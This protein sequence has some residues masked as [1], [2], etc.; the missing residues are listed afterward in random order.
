MN[1]RDVMGLSLTMEPRSY[2]SGSKSVI[3]A[4]AGMGKAYLLASM[5]SNTLTDSLTKS[6]KA[7]SASELE[8]KMNTAALA[9]YAGAA[10]AAGIASVYLGKKLYGTVQSA[11]QL[12]KTMLD[13]NIAMGNFGNNTS[14]KAINEN[15]TAVKNLQ[16]GIYD[17]NETAKSYFAISSAG[18][19][20]Q[21]KLGKDLTSMGVKYAQ[22]YQILSRGKVSMEEAANFIPELIAKTGADLENQ[23]A[24]GETQMERYMDM[25]GKAEVLTKIKMENM[26]DIIDA[27]GA[28]W[29][30]LGVSFSAGL[31]MVGQQMTAGQSARNAGQSSKS[32]YDKFVNDIALLG[33][34]K[35]LYDKSDDMV[36]KISDLNRQVLKY[37][38]AI[39][40]AYGGT[41][42]F[43]KLVN[44]VISGK[45]SAV[46]AQKDLE[47]KRKDGK[48]TSD[49]F[50]TIHKYFSQLSRATDSNLSGTKQQKR[51]L[52]GLSYLYGDEKKG[53]MDPSNIEKGREK[54][55]GMITQVRAGTLS[56]NAML[57]ELS[58][59]LDVYRK[60][61]TLED[62]N[63]YMM[64]ARMIFPESTSFTAFLNATNATQM[65]KVNQDVYKTDASGRRVR[66][67][68]LSKEEKDKVLEGVAKGLMT[69]NAA[70]L[71]KLYSKGQTIFGGANALMYLEEA[72]KDSEKLTARTFEANMK[73]YN[74]VILETKANL[75]S[76]STLVGVG[77]IEPMTTMANAMKNVT[78]VMN[79]FARYMPGFAS[80]VGNIGG[81]GAGVSGIVA[82]AMGGKALS[83]GSR[84][85][86]SLLGMPGKAINQELINSKEGLLNRKLGLMEKAAVEESKIGDAY[87][88]YNN[89]AKRYKQQLTIN[90]KKWDKAVEAGA[91]SK[92][93]R[94]AYIRGY[95]ST[96]KTK[97]SGLAKSLGY[98][99]QVLNSYGLNP[100]GYISGKYG[101][102]VSGIN[103]R[104]SMLDRSLVTNSGGFMANYKASMD[105][106][107]NTITLN[108]KG[109]QVLTTKFGKFS[110]SLWEGTK[111]GSR[112]IYGR[113][114][115]SPGAM[116]G[117][118]IAGG[119]ISWGIQGMIQNNVFGMQDAL[120][121]FSDGRQGNIPAF[122]NN[123]KNK[124]KKL[125]GG[126]VSWDDSLSAIS[127]KEVYDRIK[128]DVKSYRTTAGDLLSYREWFADL[129]GMLVPNGQEIAGPYNELLAS[130]QRAVLMSLIKKDF[131]PA[132]LGKNA[133]D[134]Y[135]TKNEVLLD[136]LKLRGLSESSLKIL[137]SNPVAMEQLRKDMI[138]ISSDKR[139]NEMADIHK[140]TQEYF[141]KQIAISKDPW[142]Y[143]LYKWFETVGSKYLYAIAAGVGFGALGAG[144]LFGKG[145]L[146]AVI[147]L[148][149][150][151][152]MSILNSRDVDNRTKVIELVGTSIAT[153][154]GGI[155][156]GFIGGTAGAQWVAT[157]TGTG[158]SGIFNLYNAKVGKEDAKINSFAK[159][160]IALNKYENLNA[161]AGILGEYS[162]G[163]YSQALPELHNG[164]YKIWDEAS[165]KYYPVYDVDS[166]GN[167]QM[168]L[169]D[170]INANQA[171]KL[172]RNVFRDYVLQDGKAYIDADVT[173]TTTN[174]FA[175]KMAEISAAYDEWETPTK[176]DGT[177]S[178]E[179]NYAATMGDDYRKALEE[180]TA[181]SDRA[182][183]ATIDLTKTLE[184][185][186]DVWYFDLAASEKDMYGR[187]TLFSKEKKIV[188][189]D[190]EG[191]NYDGIPDFRSTA[192]AE[193]LQMAMFKEG[194]GNAVRLDIFVND[195]FA[196]NKLVNSWT[197]P[198]FKPDNLSGKDW[199][200]ADLVTVGI[201]GNR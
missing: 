120:G 164:V 188:T 153:V 95:K 50:N 171:R 199:G 133:N 60:G 104:I 10:G 82:L 101:N 160:Y 193:E 65:T 175:T 109:Q 198:G 110:K 152:V 192:T 187:S 70:G 185:T 137:E 48:V 177:F 32:I 56:A 114:L 119:L 117:T 102:E 39:A 75:K 154:A 98:A 124:S 176:S 45:V 103:N 81:A 21:N 88:K 63:K 184:D 35:V 156:G 130:D 43:Q 151:S 162:I 169:R 58:D 41:A 144:A 112:A 113:T 38:E 189:P 200:R 178:P 125:T 142:A 131:A 166:E 4:T 24:N 97:T 179:L 12:Q 11:T 5:N 161:T 174:A 149:G 33:S 44:D 194:F 108:N 148:L 74:N 36:A 121:S 26:R 62:L 96:I 25:M 143:N 87:T 79:D 6:G 49:A 155:A 190:K 66:L 85:L 57:K 31:A 197:A 29:K 116:I 53:V 100:T 141:D 22:F 134:T 123:L 34:Q 61:G 2:I 69:V 86:G 139:F 7:M 89:S 118:M 67:G 37:P 27:T 28:S 8:A 150:V 106:L 147:G 1:Y 17:L 15:M 145:G 181:S 146:G 183:Q 107:N 94:D 76:F 132:D 16:R 201:G 138:D 55:T 3:S 42:V 140:S 64:V 105:R 127:N 157:A 71:I 13:V 47:D 72:N 135:K 23:F 83:L 78:G 68:E 91:I 51:L 84:G 158:V 122:F 170:D 54:Y 115:G 186:K 168:L 19:Q 191:G 40:K 159:D 46:S 30:N 126:V 111:G 90:T 99:P 129:R 20:G 182:A 80:L 165:G 52:L 196:G 9:R 173:T 93:Q 59:K 172:G 195:K 136:S 92:T 77:F 14:V 73:L 18:M 128:E 180:Q 163:A 167:E